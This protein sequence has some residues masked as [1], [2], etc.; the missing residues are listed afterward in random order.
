M[1]EFEQLAYLVEEYVEEVNSASLDSFIDENS[2]ENSIDIEDSR[3]LEIKDLILMMK[4]TDIILNCRDIKYDYKFR[5]KYHLDQSDK[6]V[7]EFL[8][9]LNPK[10]LEYYRMR[11]E[12]GSFIFDESCEKVAFQYYDFDNKKR[13]IYIPVTFT[14]EDSFSIIH[15]LFHD[16]NCS[17]SKC[18]SAGRNYFTEGISLL[19]ELLFSDFLKSKNIKEVN[20]YILKAINGLKHEALEVDFNLRLIL[21]YL[22]VGY[23][24]GYMVNDVFVSY[25]RK[26]HG[27]LREVVDY[28]CFDEKL[29]LEEEEPYVLSYLV[30]IYMYDRIKRN[31]KNLEEL[32]DLNQKLD[33]FSMEQVLDYLGIDYDDVSLTSES[34]D[35]LRSGFVKFIKR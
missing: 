35:I 19:G 7:E 8:E 10:Y 2:V 27:F 12:D 29:T 26:Y 3:P 5:Q 33:D 21:E 31:K 15:E 34:Y 25:P 22:K 17:G 11:K 32:F 6:L 23:I 1:D 14:L 4:C 13:L 9:I 18:D 30:A 16:I 24:D 28:I 20:N